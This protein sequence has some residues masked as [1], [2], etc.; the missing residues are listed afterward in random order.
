MSQRRR[1]LVIDDSEIMLERIKS[2][3]ES[4][5]YEVMTTTH[6]VGNARYLP[7]CDLVII[8]Y[9]M[10]GLN[11]AAVLD[12][13]RALTSTM[14]HACPLFVYTSD[15]KIAA[16]HAQLGF[17]G[18]LAAKGDERTLVRQL[19]TLFRTLDM[20]AERGRRAASQPPVAGTG[21]P[22]SKPRA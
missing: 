19:A 8:D 13:L 22:A 6:V 17:D 20:R 7:T 1:I 12:S 4:E 21:P 9:H 18:A 10:P 16:A 14:K 5:G 11:G 2:A 15:E 3:L